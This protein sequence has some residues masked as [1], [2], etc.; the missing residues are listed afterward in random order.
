MKFWKWT[1]DL[2]KNVLRI[3]G[4]ISDWKVD[5][6]DSLTTPKEFRNELNSCKG[7]IELII[8]S[9]GGNV[10]SAAEIYSMLKEY[11]KGEI[12]AKIPAFCASAASVIAMA[13]KTIEISPLAFLCIH[14]PFVDVA[15]GT[16]KDLSDGAKFLHD[17]KENIINVYQQKT[18]LP[19]EKISALMD[20]E[21]YM[22]AQKAIELHFADK[23]MFSDEEGTTAQMYSP[24]R[25]V[26]LL[27]KIYQSSNDV[28]KSITKDP[29]R[30]L[31]L[32]R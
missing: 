12:T 8:N 25:D 4:V 22:N 30:R 24:R 3:D 9:P 14:N 7:N 28:E 17:L 26:N 20:A 19:R 6:D 10:F 16:E 11:D 29:R 27:F 1:K 13:A 21:T 2:A 5:D 31:I 32:G 18:G 23:L 15:F